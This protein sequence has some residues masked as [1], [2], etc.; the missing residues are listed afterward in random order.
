MVDILRDNRDEQKSFR[1][2]LS[3]D[4]D[5]LRHIVG[6]ERTLHEEQRATNARVDATN[7][8]LDALTVEVL[9]SVRTEALADIRQYEGRIRR[10]EEAVFKPAAE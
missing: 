8:R 7:T 9:G 6:A 1:T 5:A 3:G 10:L 2:E 4:T